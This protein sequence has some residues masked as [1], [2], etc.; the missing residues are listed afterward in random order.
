MDQVLDLH[1]GFF[2]IEPGDKFRFLRRDPPCA[3]P[4]VTGAADPAAHCNERRSPDVDR[5]CA[6][7]DRLC[8]IGTLPDAAAC[9]DGDLV[10]DPLL[11]EFCIHACDR[12]LDRDADMVPEYPGGGSC[13]ATETVNHD[14]IRRRP[15]N[16]GG[17]RRRVVDRRDLDK[18]RLLPLGRFLEA[19]HELLQVFDAVDIMVGSGADRIASLRDHPGAGNIRTDLLARQVPAKAGLC[20]LPDLDLDRRA[21]FKVVDINPEPAGCNLHDHMALVRVERLVEPALAGT[22][23]R[24]DPVHGFCER[25]LGIQAYCPVAHVPDH[26]GRLDLE[27][28]REFCLELDIAFCGCGFFEHDPRRFLPEIGPE[29]H[30]FPQGID[31]GI[32]DLAGVEHEPVEDDRVRHRVA[33]AGEDDLPGTRLVEDRLPGLP[34]PDRMAPVIGRLLFDIDSIPRAEREA[35]VAGDAVPGIDPDPVVLLPVHAVRAVLNAPAADHT[36]FRIDRDPEPQRDAANCHAYTFPMT[37]SPAFG[38]V[39]ESTSGS[40]RRI[41]ASSLLM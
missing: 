5:I 17:N 31:G 41:A 40:I 35:A 24:P 6:K 14:R 39:M 13:A 37:G 20:P 28:R 25:L 7:A 1:R 11:P 12:R 23:E 22:H 4:P 15:G 21:A 32:G 9:D 26:D 8:D 34:G 3:V 36:A 16:P 19:P 2:G 27:V 18:D 30:R 10:P 38:I 29:L 33:H